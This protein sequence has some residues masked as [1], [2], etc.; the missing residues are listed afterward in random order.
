MDHFEDMVKSTTDTPYPTNFDIY[1]G[2]ES[3]VVTFLIIG[4]MACNMMLLLFCLLVITK[5]K[6][7]QKHAKVNDKNLAISVIDRPY[8]HNVELVSAK[9][10]N[11][12]SDGNR[13]AIISA[14]KSHANDKQ[15][16]NDN[17]IRMWL[18]N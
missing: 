14:A 9:H 13:H 7:E 4:I 3:E 11:G 17:T 2:E 8:A 6:K 15:D 18:Q 1:M 10:D 12:N 5:I 16:Y